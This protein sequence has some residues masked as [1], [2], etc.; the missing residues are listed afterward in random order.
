MPGRK[1]MPAQTYPWERRRAGRPSPQGV[2]QTGCWEGCY[3][4]DH[5]FPDRRYN[6]RHYICTFS[7][8]SSSLRYCIGHRARSIALRTLLPLCCL[9]LFQDVFIVFLFQ[10]V[11]M[12]CFL[13]RQKVEELLHLIIFSGSPQIGIEFKSTA[14]PSSWPF[15]EYRHRRDRV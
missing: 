11:F 10:T 13:L 9:R 12:F 6:H 4:R 2:F 14:P 1:I 15:A 3:C 7:S 5:R 8:F